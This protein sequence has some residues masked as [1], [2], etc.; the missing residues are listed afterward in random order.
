MKGIQVVGILVSLYLLAQT[1]LNYRRGNY[2][3][4]RALFFFALWGLVAF[5]FVYPS[6]V[7]FVL[8]I[9]TT[10]DMIMSVLVVGLVITFVLISELYQQI[11]RIEK[12]ITELVQN[13]AIRDYLSEFSDRKDE[14]DR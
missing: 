5:L 9:L 13:L 10:Q 3:S 12:R 6:S 11:G 8:P 2:S 14:D 4:K 1:F 7:Q